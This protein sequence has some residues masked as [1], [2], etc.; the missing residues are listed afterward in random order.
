MQEGRL[1]PDRNTFAEEAIR[2]G[3][4]R[5]LSYRLNTDDLFDWIEVQA[6]KISKFGLC[7]DF[8][9]DLTTQLLLTQKIGH[10]RLI[11]T[12]HHS[13]RG[14]LVAEKNE[15]II[16]IRADLPKDVRRY[17]IAH[18]IGHTLW[19]K[20]NSQLSPLSPFQ[21]LGR[22]SDIEYLCDWFG[23]ALLLP[24]Y[25]LR[26]LSWPIGEDYTRDNLASLICDIRHLTKQALVPERIVAGRILSAAIK[27]R[28][29]AACLTFYPPSD[30]MSFFSRD[31]PAYW[32]MSWALQSRRVWTNE[33]WCHLPNAVQKSA[34]HKLQPNRVP[35][36]AEETLLSSEDST[37]MA[38][39]ESISHL[40]PFKCSHLAQGSCFIYKIENKIYILYRKTE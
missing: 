27:D 29:A 39:L 17:V 5:D 34:G 28:W 1:S 32:R 6:E 7:S 36:I 21:A 16:E 38:L 15:L 4:A 19:L 23:A 37:G 20:P 2:L 8:Y 10:I 18:E 33:R 31:A 13:F 30:Q 24:K 25:I 12:P 35:N 40:I 22:D 3:L 9:V 14:R 11:K 26:H